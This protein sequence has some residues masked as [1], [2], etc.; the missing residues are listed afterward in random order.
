VDLSGL[1][2]SEKIGAGEGQKSMAWKESGS[3]QA[4][5]STAPVLQTYPSVCDASPRRIGHTYPH[6]L[7]APSLATRVVGSGLCSGLPHLGWPV[8]SCSVS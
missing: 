8:H 6:E 1:I 4:T 5:L 7:V 2:S 3:I